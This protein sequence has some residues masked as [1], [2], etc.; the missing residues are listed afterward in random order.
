[1]SVNPEETKAKYESIV[2]SVLAN[3][4]QRLFDAMPKECFQRL[5]LD[6]WSTEN[7]L[8]MMLLEGV[9]KIGNADLTADFERLAKGH[10]N[11]MGARLWQKAHELGTTTTPLPEEFR[12]YIDPEAPKPE[13]TP[14]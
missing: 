11:L 5:M 9:L 12:H 4:D 3:I 13:S 7:K 1:M 6:S 8:A 10:M 2:K 14:A